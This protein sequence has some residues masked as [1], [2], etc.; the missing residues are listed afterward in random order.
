MHLRPFVFEYGEEL[1]DGQTIVRSI[2]DH[3]GGPNIARIETATP[4]AVGVGLVEELTEGP[5]HCLLK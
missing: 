3:Q 2:F 5:C 1:G 4:V